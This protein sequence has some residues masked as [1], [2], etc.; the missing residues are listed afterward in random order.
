MT[1][2]VLTLATAV[3]ALALAGCGDTAGGSAANLDDISTADPFDQL[4]Y[5]SGHGAAQQFIAQYDSTFSYDL[6]AKGFQDGAAGDSAQI[7][8]ALGLRAGLELRADTLSNINADVFLAGLSEGLNGDSLRLT[9][10]QIQAAFAVV[11]DS[12]SKRQQRAQE[13]AEM[14]QLREQAAT[15]PAAA[16]RLAAI[17]TNRAVADS[18]MTAVRQRD[19]I[20]ELDN[21]VLYTVNTPGEGDSP[22]PQSEVTIEYTGRFIDG[23]V[24][25]QSPPGEPVTYPIRIFVEGF[26][27]SVLD[28]QPGESRTIYLPPSLA[29]GLLGA[30]G[31]QGEEGIPPNSALEFDITLVSFND[32]PQAPGFPQ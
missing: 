16:E 4:A 24:F 19:G 29:Y 31:P 3:G 25:D 8:Y 12:L 23:E 27:T 18:F 7:A 14:A 20:Q 22:T 6:F 9:Q 1:L 11:E 17:S 21:G 15:D 5:N 30:P 28:M 26:R 2:R 10:D 13:A 32:A